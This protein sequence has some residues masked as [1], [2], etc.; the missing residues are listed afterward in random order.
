MP[1]YMDAKAV[2]PGCTF[3]RAYELG[4]VSGSRGK[5]E[6]PR[7][8]LEGWHVHCTVD[9]MGPCTGEHRESC[10]RSTPGRAQVMGTKRKPVKVNKVKQGGPSRL[11]L[12]VD[13]I[14]FEEGE[15]SDDRIIAFFQ[16]LV[17]TGLA[18]Q[19]Q[20]SYGRM[21]ARLIEAGTIQARRA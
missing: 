4:P 7:P 3:K 9:D 13:I 2:W 17:D 10:Y 21:A 6:S 1:R 12:F 8:A 20:G 18:W 16:K 15:M 14:D 5:G 11:D 19:L